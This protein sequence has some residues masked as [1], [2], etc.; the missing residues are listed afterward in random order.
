MSSAIFSLNSNYFMSN[1]YLKKFSSLKASRV[2]LKL[3]ISHFSTFMLNFFSK[4][5]THTEEHI[6][7]TGRAQLVVTK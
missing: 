4:H 6:N 3:K 7:C 1:F 2:N 5:S